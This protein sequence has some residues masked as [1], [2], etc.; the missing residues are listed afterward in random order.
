MGNAGQ[1]GG[2][3]AGAA[4]S[5]VRDAAIGADTIAP[6][7]TIA[8]NGTAC[9][10]DVYTSTVYVT[11]PSTDVGSAVASTHYTTDGSDPTLVSPTYSTP[12]PVTSTTTIKF[13]S[14]D[15]AGNTDAIGSQ[16][17]QANLPPDTTAP[18]TTIACGGAP[19][20]GAGYNGSTVV[21]LTATDAGGWGVDRTFYT[22]DGTAPNTRAAPCTPGRSP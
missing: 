15:N 4:L 3:P 22:T 14:W 5:T 21:T 19:C 13:R 20:S 11:L 10:P 6:V 17:I 8:C 12:I 7:T 2:A 16:V 9:A 1:A 18:A